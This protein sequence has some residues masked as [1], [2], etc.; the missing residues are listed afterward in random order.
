MTRG[1]ACRILGVS[2]GAAPDQIKRKYR[3]L[4][5]RLH[6]DVG[7]SEEDLH[8]AWQVNAAYALLKRTWPAGD[9]SQAG[10]ETA[11]GVF[12]RRDTCHRSC[13]SAA[14]RSAWDA[15]V[16]SHA[17]RERNILCCA[18]DSEGEVIGT[19][20][21]ARG[22]YFW[23]TEEDFP[24]FLRS[25]YLCGKE[26]LDE[27]DASLER[28][29]S[30]S[31]RSRFH[32]ALTYLL[33]QQYI[34]ASSLLKELAARTSSDREGQEIYY[35]PAML[36]TKGKGLPG[37]PGSLPAD[38][39][40]FPSGVRDRRLYLKDISG[41]EAGYLS[42]SDDRLYYVLVP[43]FEQRQVLVRLR[44]AGEGETSSL[45]AGKRAAAR[46]KRSAGYRRLHLWL[47]FKKEEDKSRLP[48]SLNL[49]ISQLLEHYMASLS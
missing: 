10:P 22:R 31:C 38:A 6:P 18:E 26:L 30:P 46:Q 44:A 36:E 24:L 11:S 7:P 41:Q 47:K 17:Y 13:R 25:I 8:L 5:H 32:A 33:A 2:P 27:V 16:N 19:F 23:T 14:R 34:D 12:R 29:S 9:A 35:F 21:A 43:L 39:P 20:T 1:E 42:F 4:M 37:L 48:E 45:S 3:Q 15:P 40:L 49:Q 28:A